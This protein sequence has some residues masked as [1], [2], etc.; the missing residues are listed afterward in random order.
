MDKSTS[1]P[2]ERIERER[3]EIDIKGA[4]TQN[5][6]SIVRVIVRNTGHVKL[7]DFDRWDIVIE[8]Y[9][10]GEKEEDP[11]VLEQAWLPYTE[12]SLNDMQWT[13]ERNLS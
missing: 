13:S 2:T 6:G 10:D 9:T 11:N 3:T 4:E 8:Y 1:K 5:N 7:A 12:G